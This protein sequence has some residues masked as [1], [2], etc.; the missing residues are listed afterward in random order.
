[1]FV[2]TSFR[3]AILALAVIPVL[4]TGVLVA[5]PVFNSDTGAF[6]QALTHVSPNN[7]PTQPSRN[8]GG[9]E[10]NNLSFERKLPLCPPGAAAVPGQ[11]RPWTPPRR[12]FSSMDKCDCEFITRAGRKVRDCYVLINEKV[13]YCINDRSKK[14]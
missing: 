2:T 13:Q 3:K 11:C 6:A 12:K 1:M 9:G 7:R 5:E 14:F 8:D 10:G 4:A